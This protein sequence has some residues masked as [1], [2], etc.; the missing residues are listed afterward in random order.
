[1]AASLIANQ[2]HLDRRSRRI[3]TSSSVH[4][5]RVHEL[6]SDRPADD[7]QLRQQRPRCLQRSIDFESV[8][9]TPAVCPRYSA[10]VDATTTPPAPGG[11]S[12]TPISATEVSLRWT[13]TA[14]ETGYHI[15]R[16]TG[17]ACT[18]FAEVAQTQANVVATFSNA[19]LASGT[20]R[21]RPLSQGVQPG[22]QLLC[23]VEHRRGD[24]PS[25]HPPRCDVI[26]HLE[27]PGESGVD[28]RGVAQRACA[29]N[30]ARE[31]GAATSCR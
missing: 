31:P 14:G 27:R 3:G 20:L 9:T 26:S 18:G 1:M 23:R 28:R 21:R 22:W 4:R 12:V 13:D 10:A 8:P 19:G 6:R 24:D 5:R 11:L 29:S 7:H 2:R 25:A 17:A 15:E 16:W 30:G